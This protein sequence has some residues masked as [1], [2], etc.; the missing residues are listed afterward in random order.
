VLY[1]GR[2]AEIGPTMDVLKAAQHPYTKGLIASIPRMNRPMQRLFQIRGTMPPAGQRPD[3][4]AFHPRCPAAMPH[5]TRERPPLI[6]R[7][8]TRA[9]CWLL[10]PLVASEGSAR[11]DA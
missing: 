10:D 11:Q 7:A 9:A 4:C 2:I 1:A 3:G 6:T 5:C 8:P